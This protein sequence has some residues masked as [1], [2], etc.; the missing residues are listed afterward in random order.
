M[1]RARERLRR[2]GRPE[3]RRV[4]AVVERDAVE[5]GSDPHDLPG[6]AELVERRRLVPGD[7]ARED[8]G[9]PEGDGEREALQRNQRL[10]QRRAAVDP[11]PGGQKAAE[12]GL[13]CGL[14]L[15]PE[16]RERSTA[17][18]PEDVRV[19]PF[20]LH[21]SRPELTPDEVVAGLETGE[22]LVDLIGIEGVASGGLAGRGRPARAREPRQYPLDRVGHRFEERLRK[23]AGG[24]HAECVPIE[25]GI[26]RGDHGGP[27]AD[28][29][30][31]RAPLANER[32]GEARVELP[33]AEVADPAEQVVEPVG[34]ARLREQRGLDLRERTGVDQVAELFLAEQLPQELAVERQCLRA[35]LCRRRVVLVHVGGDVVEEQ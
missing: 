7:A 15:A 33:V 8:L 27:F 14:H 10:T 25:A 30:A 9:L 26:L 11:V 20:P 29:G 4:I 16:H 22:E 21:P 12:R 17:D 24:H 34:V 19:A 32:L 31:E 1:H 13:L 28:A 18:T 23:A 2:S 5:T 3:N 35:A 6:G